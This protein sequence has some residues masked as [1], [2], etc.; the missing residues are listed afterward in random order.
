MLR[1]NIVKT[2][3]IISQKGGSG[4]TT[5]A[6][7]LAVAAH[8]SGL[9]T[10]IID[11]DPQASA[12]KW[13][14]RRG[15]DPQVISDHA[16]MVADLIEAARKNGADLILIDTPPAADRAA[17]AAARVSDLLLIPSRPTVLDVEAI[18]PSTDLATLVGKPAYVIFSACPIR[19]DGAIAEAR[20]GLEARGVQVADVAIFQRATYAHSLIDGRTAI[21]FEPGGKAAAE[22]TRLREWLTG[23]LSAC[24]NARAA[25]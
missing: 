17:G 16:E 7:H 14:K 20:A 3:A 13:G 24:T 5:L 4:K 23:C 2:V 22:I 21:E 11:L 10:A 18:R 1:G 25:A 15:E 6:I 19:S 9:R 8:R 12:R